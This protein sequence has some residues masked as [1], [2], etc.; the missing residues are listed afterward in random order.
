MNT[1]MPVSQIGFTTVLPGKQCDNQCVRVS[2]QS[3]IQ[4]TMEHLNKQ[5]QK[6]PLPGNHRFR[7]DLLHIID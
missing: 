4:D 5:F 6:K 1:S 7:I 3:T 2:T